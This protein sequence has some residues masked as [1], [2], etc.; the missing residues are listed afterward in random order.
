MNSLRFAGVEN[1]A[2]FFLHCCVFG[3]QEAEMAD[4]GN[5]TSVQ[6][7]KKPAVLELKIT[8]KPC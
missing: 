3:L 8:F 2:V 4:R 1:V 6:F 5:F 7:D